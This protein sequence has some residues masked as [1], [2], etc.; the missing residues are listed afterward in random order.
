[1]NFFVSVAAWQSIFPPAWWWR[2]GGF[3]QTRS[4]CRIQPVLVATMEVLEALGHKGNFALGIF[5]SGKQTMQNQNSSDETNKSRIHASFPNQSAVIFGKRQ[6]FGYTLGDPSHAWGFR[7]MLS[8]PQRSLAH[9]NDPQELKHG[10]DRQSLRG[11]G[12]MLTGPTNGPDQMSNTST[13]SIC[14]TIMYRTHLVLFDMFMH[15]CHTSN[16]I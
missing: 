10:F 3:V 8:P 1:M 15:T 7:D 2:N 16:I 13:R 12:G 5:S 14:A 4:F 6:K 9:P 11:W